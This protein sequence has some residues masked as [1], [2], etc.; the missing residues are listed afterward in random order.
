MDFLVCSLLQE[1]VFGEPLSSNGLPLWLY[2][3]GFQESCHNIIK[4]NTA[5]ILKVSDKNY[6]GSSR[7]FIALH[8][9]IS[10]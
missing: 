7:V 5:A 2:Y 4:K 10:F 8:V 6:Y 1:R 3:S 9:P